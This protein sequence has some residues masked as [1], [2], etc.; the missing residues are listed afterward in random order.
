MFLKWGEGMRK[1]FT[2]VI[3]TITVLIVSILFGQLLGGFY[4]YNLLVGDNLS[5]EHKEVKLQATPMEKRK[6]LRLE[7]IDFYTIQVG[8][9]PEV[10]SAQSSI[11]KLVNLGLRPFVSSEPPFKIWVGCFGEISL[12]KELENALKQQGFDAF[13][14]KGLIN[15]RALKF[16]SNNIFM[17]EKFAPLLG[18]YDL[19]LRHSIKMFRSP[20]ISE[21]SLDLWENMITKVQ[22]EISEA[23]TYLDNLKEM[24]ESKDYHRELLNL[25]EK[26]I[27]YGQSLNL[28]L[29]SKS[30]EAVL[31]S[32]GH[33]LELIAAYHNLITNTNE[34]LGTN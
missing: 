10:K 15:D 26:A 34:K 2:L 18:K 25:K 21:Y 28:I 33:L 9:Y 5:L 17:K 4:I 7:P 8:I 11:D 1:L 22:S 16:P 19:V 24:E 6:V 20:K 31:Y 12:G 32:Q 13:R 29:K 3:A 30:D 27:S 23:V 14:G